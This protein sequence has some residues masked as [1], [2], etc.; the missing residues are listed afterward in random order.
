MTTKL[1]VIS[2]RYKGI[3]LASPHCTTTHPM[4]SREKN[5][6][7]NMLQ[8]W[9]SDAK[10]LDAYA[11]TGALGIEA[12]SRGAQSAVFVESHPVVM[13]TLR[14]NLA[15]LSPAP[16]TETVIC[17]VAQILLTH[18]D[19]QGIFNLIIADP[20]YDDFSSSE[21]TAL[22]RLLAPNGILAVSYPAKLGDLVL[23]GLK[24][25]SV[26]HYAAAGIAVYR[27]ISRSVV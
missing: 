19:W 11:G 21:I 15:Q 20:P 24:C 17:S 8:P 7:F 10:V 3:K 22:A 18:P 25:L 16:R 14:A 13:R 27:Q 6:L 23:P 5:A 4:G 26:R 9:I 2:G 1:S 12:L